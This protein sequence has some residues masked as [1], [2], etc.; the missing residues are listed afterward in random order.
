MNGFLSTVTTAAN[1][2]VKADTDKGILFD[3]VFA[4]TGLASDGWIILPN[5][6]SL[7]R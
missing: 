6:I 4:T 3:A 1:R 5:G 7:G 2:P